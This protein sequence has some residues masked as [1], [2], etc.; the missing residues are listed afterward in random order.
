MYTIKYILFFTFLTQISI[1]KSINIHNRKRLIKT[2]KPKLCCNEKR[3]N[4]GEERLHEGWSS[5]DYCHG[6][7]GKRYGF[8]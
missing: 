7:R 2:G 3:A 6:V 5:Y 1:I 4:H 8:R